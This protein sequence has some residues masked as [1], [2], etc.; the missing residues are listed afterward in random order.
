ML[1]EEEREQHKL[2]RKI[3]ARGALAALRRHGAA[4]A[5]HAPRSASCTTLRQERARATRRRR[6]TVKLAA[7]EADISGKLV[8]EA[9]GRSPRASA[10]PTVVADFSIRILRGDRVGIVG[11]N[12]AGKTTLLKLLTGELAPDSGTV[13]LGANLADGH[14]RPAPR[15]ASTR[16]GRWREALTG[17]RGDHGRSSTASAGTSSAT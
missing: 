8:V 17:G 13:R 3:V 4:Q 2:D 9:E 15:R 12:G 14:A 6:A 1:E 5:Q 16:T 11:P 10:S 7:A